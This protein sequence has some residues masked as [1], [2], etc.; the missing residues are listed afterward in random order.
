MPHLVGD[1]VKNARAYEI[2]EMIKDA[3][4]GSLPPMNP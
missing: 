3:Q 2:R 4:D 1:E